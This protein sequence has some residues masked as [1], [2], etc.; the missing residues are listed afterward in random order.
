MKKN[1][2]T[3]DQMLRFLIAFIALS[4]YLADCINGWIAIL[5]LVILMA[6]ALFSFC[7]LYRIFNISTKHKHR[8]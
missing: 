4:L 3:K 1:I 7:P 6:T 5:L 2:G 8:N